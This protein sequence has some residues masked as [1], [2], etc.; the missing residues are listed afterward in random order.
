MAASVIQGEHANVCGCL[1]SGAALRLGWRPADARVVDEVRSHSS[2]KPESREQREGRQA[3]DATDPHRAPSP[4]SRQKLYED[5]GHVL[6]LRWTRP[7]HSR[8]DKYVRICTRSLSLL[9]VRGVGLV[10]ALVSKYGDRLSDLSGKKTEE[11]VI[12]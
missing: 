7:G 1:V 4:S 6:L 3:T 9:Q 11:L 5:S 10:S 2:P 8:G 12:H